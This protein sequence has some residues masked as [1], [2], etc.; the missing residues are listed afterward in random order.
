M[1][2]YYKLNDEKCNF[3]SFF[4]VLITNVIMNK[5]I[6]MSIVLAGFCLQ[7]QAQPDG[8]SISPQMLKEIK[9]SY[10]GTPADKAIRN[11][12]CNNDIRK[13]AL[14]QE[15]MVAMDTYFSN[16]V[17]SKGITNQQSS[18]RCWLFT[19]LNVLRAKMIAKY[20]LGS[21]EFSQSYVFFWD[22]LEKANLFLQG[23][24]DTRT[25]PLDDKMVEWLF[26]NPLSDGGQFTGVSDLVSKY[27][28]VPAS[29]P[30]YEIKEEIAQ[31][32]TVYEKIVASL[33]LTE[34]M[35]I[36]LECR[37][38]DLSY[39]EIG[40]VLSRAQATVYEYFIKMRRR[41]MA[42]YE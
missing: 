35:R 6:L 27:G 25:K 3:A 2:Y 41:Y 42:I 33:N 20:N 9:Q 38:N 16:K 34:N 37:Q 29:E 15:N 7:T 8:G 14:N 36:A 26:K 18:G 40:R 39:P 22:Q 10:V 21:F 12:I 23:V 4:F 32:Y 17:E 5:Q 11:A 13:L 24:I 30:S 19:G 31:D 28:L 1:P